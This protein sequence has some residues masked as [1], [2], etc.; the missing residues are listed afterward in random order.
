MVVWS[1]LQVGMRWR[2]HPGLYYTRALRSRSD[3]RV[4]LAVVTQEV[5][6][7]GEAVMVVA[8][9][10]AAKECDL[11]RCFLYMSPLVPI[12]ILRVQE[13]FKADVA[14]MGTFR[15][16]EVGL[17]VT[18]DDTSQHGILGIYRSLVFPATWHSRSGHRRYL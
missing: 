3:S 2:R 6:A 4:L 14:F 16:T 1:C 18:T 17:A 5:I 15:A 9:R 12:K 8:T 11:V 7:S 13:A 10:Y